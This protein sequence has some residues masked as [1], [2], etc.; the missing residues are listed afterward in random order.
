MRRDGRGGACR[1]LRLEA[2]AHLLD[3]VL[4]PAEEAIPQPDDFTLPLREHL[5]EHLLQI[6]EELRALRLPRRRGDHLGQSKAVAVASRRPAAVQRVHVVERAHVAQLIYHRAV[7]AHL[8]RDLVR[9]GA[10]AKLAK[11]LVGGAVHLLPHEVKLRRHPHGSRLLRDGARDLHAD[12]LRGVRGEAEAER[13]VVLLCGADEPQR[14][15]L[16]QVAPRDDAAFGGVPARDGEDEAQVGEHQLVVGGVEVLQARGV[17]RGGGQAEE[18]RHLAVGGLAAEGGAG[19]GAEAAPLEEGVGEGG[20]GVDL[21][22]GEQLVAEGGGEGRRG[23][24]GE[25]EGAAAAEARRVR[26]GGRGGERE[27]ERL[28]EEAL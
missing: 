22:G 25:A 16:H 17:L 9:C 6:K 13:R 11:Q 12:P 4:S 28:E 7:D 1:S 27:E 19:G 14:A 8:T 26:G 21:V 20:E 18:A 24:E 5:A 15:L 23:A 10:A 3:A 2:R